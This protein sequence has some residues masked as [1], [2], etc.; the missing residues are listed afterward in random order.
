[1]NKLTVYKVQLFLEYIFSNILIEFVL[2]MCIPIAFFSFETEN[3]GH[4]KPMRGNYM[5]RGKLLF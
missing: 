2:M 3:H 4:F 1:M 5:V